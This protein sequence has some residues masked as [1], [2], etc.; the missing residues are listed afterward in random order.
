[1][2]EKSSIALSHEMRG[3]TRSNDSMQ[4]NLLLDM[5]FVA[6]LGSAITAL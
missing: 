5:V 4:E 3:N 1:M 2:L 6:I